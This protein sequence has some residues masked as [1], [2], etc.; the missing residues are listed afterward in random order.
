MEHSVYVIYELY[1]TKRPC[2][3]SL[4][5]GPDGAIIVCHHRTSG[6]G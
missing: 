2:A 6:R 3:G 4:L 5:A 1:F